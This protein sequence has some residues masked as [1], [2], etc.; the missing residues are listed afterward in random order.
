MADLPLALLGMYQPSFS[1]TGVDRFGPF[2]VKIGHRTEK[3]WRV[4]FKH[5][6][7]LYIHIDL[8]SGLD[9]DAFLLAL[10]RFIAWRGTPHKMLSGQETNFHS[11]ERT[12][13]G[14]DLEP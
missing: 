8:L 14:S 3:C 2:V 13:G 9:T 5:L 7:T 6:S 12:K 1:S 11:A 4:I 10:Q